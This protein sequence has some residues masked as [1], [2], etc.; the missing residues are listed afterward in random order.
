MELRLRESQLADI[1]FLNEMLY[2][3][4]FWR[5]SASRPS[6]DEGLAYPEVSRSLAY[7]GERDG[8]TSV[9]ATVHSVKVGAAWY[10][11]WTDDNFINGYIDEMTPV[12]VIG[13]HR[14]YRRKGIGS[15]MIDWLIDR[16]S[17]DAIP[18]ISLS[19]SKDNYALNLYRQQGFL[20]Y[21]DKGDALL[22]V[23]NV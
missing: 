5:A 17:K 3:A 12:L 16:A 20:E 14:D 21:A 7:W 13:V 11:Y 4:V 9:V 8:D 19:V 2:E 10:R 15:K 1:P 18:R 23:R 22:M 6:F